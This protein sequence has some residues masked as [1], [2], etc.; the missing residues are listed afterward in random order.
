MPDI[1]VTNTNDSGAGSLRQAIADATSGQSIGFSV[2]GTI[3]LTSGELVINKNLSITGPGAGSLAISG[4]DASR[5]FSISGSAV[6]TIDGLTI[7]NGYDTWGGGGI[8]ITSSGDV[9]FQNCIIENCYVESSTWGKG[10]GIYAYASSGTKSFV[11][12]IIRNN[13]VNRTF[14]TGSIAGGLWGGNGCSLI[15]DKCAFYGNSAYGYGA[16]SNSGA[17]NLSGGSITVRNSTFSGNQAEGSYAA[18][19]F[20]GATV[21]FCSFVDNTS[22]AW[23]AGSAGVNFGTGATVTNCLFIGTYDGSSTA[24][25]DVVGTV[26][27]M[28]D[29]IVNDYSGLTITNDLGG[30][31]LGTDPLVDVL[32]LV[33]GT[34]VHPIDDTSPAY[35]AGSCGSVTEDQRGVSRPQG[36]YCDIGAYE[37]PLPTVPID[38]SYDLS[39]VVSKTLALSKNYDLRLVVSKILAVSKSYDLS[40]LVF[41]DILQVY[42]LSLI[43][44]K[45]FSINEYQDAGDVNSGSTLRAIK[46]SIESK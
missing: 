43:V 12:C 42:D 27:N 9:T 26:E 39:L 19:V 40:L 23:T 3:T 8:Y 35:E 11:N 45:V 25:S 44:T 36:T 31:Q 22:T 13:E 41:K 30:N 46:T 6:V 21:D 5:V 2:T 33:D 4:N 15:I 28:G 14:T 24:R 18:G 29:C 17:V 20:N 32:Q 16:A 38:K 1:T 10:G 34:Y 7:T 37:Y